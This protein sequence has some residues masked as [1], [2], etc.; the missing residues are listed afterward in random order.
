M[1]LI[2][3][4]TPV[5]PPFAYIFLINFAECSASQQCLFIFLHCLILQVYNLASW[6]FTFINLPLVL[7]GLNLDLRNLPSQWAAN[8]N[9]YSFPPIEA[10]ENAGWL[11]LGVVLRPNPGVDLSQRNDCCLS[12]GQEK[13]ERRLA[14]N[15]ILLVIR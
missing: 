15:L 8:S 3:P 13:D 10:L 2:M 11:S 12:A 5:L 6:V 14:V 1:V 9:A 4:I 7:S